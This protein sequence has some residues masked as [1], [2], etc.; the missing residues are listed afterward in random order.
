MCQYSSFEGLANDWHLVHLGSRAVGGD[1][2]VMLEASAV[3][4]EGRITPGD[5]GIWD[6]KHI[7][8]L[9]RITQF[10][11]AQG[12]IAGI[13]L[14]HAGR[15]GSCNL[16]WKGGGRLSEGAENGWEVVAPSAI[17]FQD[18]EPLP[19]ALSL[20]GIEQIIK[21]FESAALRALKAGFKVIEIHAAHGYLL[22]EFLSPIS[23]QRSDAYGGSIENRIS[24]LVQIAERIRRL[25]PDE[26]PLFVRISATDWVDKGWDLPQSI[27]LAHA[28]KKI[29][30]DLLDI[31]SGGMVPKATIPI[32]QGYQVPFAKAIRHQVG[33]KTAAVG[34]ITEVQQ[35]NDIITNGD[36]D[37]IFLGRELLR[38]PYW[39]L[40]A[41]QKLGEDPL[42]PLQYGYALKRRAK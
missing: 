35:S 29:G 36:A 32:G 24:L 9:S 37:L 7:P 39:A 16:P 21:A 23:N 25:M 1:A 14:A 8:P 5:M 33:I 42:W 28:L 3:T 22:H 27:L 17:P 15:K 26:L 13:Q 6:D 4:P 12:S 38:E 11:H 10:I 2:L 30:V 19:K 18:R 41:Q 31:S 34:L 20:A 40:K